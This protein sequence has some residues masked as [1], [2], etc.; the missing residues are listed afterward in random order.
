MATADNTV[1]VAS[2]RLP[3][4][5]YANF[6]NIKNVMC[7]SHETCACENGKWESRRTI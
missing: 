1:F 4:F 6:T 5:A 7:H 2:L 3:K